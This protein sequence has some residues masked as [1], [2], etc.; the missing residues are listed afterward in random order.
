MTV[1][2]TLQNLQVLRSKFVSYDDNWVHLKGQREF[3]QDVAHSSPIQ[4]LYEEGRS[5]ALYL[6]GGLDTSYVNKSMLVDEYVR[7]VKAAIPPKQNYESIGL[8]AQQDF[9]TNYPANY[10]VQYMINQYWEQWETVKRVEQ[11]LSKLITTPA[12]QPLVRSSPMQAIRKYVKNWEQDAQLH[13]G[14][15]ENALRAQLVVALKSEGFLTGAE[16]NASQGH[17]D[18]VVT[19]LLVGSIADSSHQLVAECKIWSGSKALFAALSQLCQYV[20]PNDAHAALIV[21]VTEGSFNDTCDKAAQCLFEHPAWGTSSGG[22]EYIE[23]SLKPAQ[24]PVSEIPATLLMCNLTT[25]RYSRLKPILSTDEKMTDDIFGVD[26]RLTLKPVVE[27]NTLLRKAFGNGPC[28]CIR[29]KVSGGEESGYEHQHTFKF[30]GYQTNRRFTC[31]SGS[32][33]LLVLKKAWFSYTKSEFEVRGN[34][35]LETI[36]E[37]VEPDLHIRLVPL[38]IAS[39]L[40]KDIGGN[41]ELQAQ[42]AD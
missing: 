12:F 8:E 11:F 20:T 39:G 14:L 31:S 25:P 23:F 35:P 1:A 32:D 24:N 33:V 38:L 9:N 29:C 18:I 5:C 4:K 42:V 7:N 3:A 41:L 19:K 13:Q 40:V 36:K 28:T 22:T 16:T 10:T 2:D 17:A 27:F 26:K 37:F 6:K 30:E 21:F 15:G 34:F